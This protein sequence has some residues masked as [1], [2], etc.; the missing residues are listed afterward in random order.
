MMLANGRISWTCCR[1]D[2]NARNGN[3]LSLLLVVIAVGLFSAAAEPASV[4]ILGRQYVRVSDWA[5]KSGL[6]MRWLKQDE[7]LQLGNSRFKIRLTINSSDADVNGVDVRLLFPVAARNGVPYLAQL[8]ADDTLRPILFPPKNRPGTTVKTICLDPGHGGNDPGYKIAGR[9]E[10]N[11]TLLLG[12]ELR[13]QLV[14]AGFKVSLTRTS[15]KKIELP[16]R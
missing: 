2:V 13:D 8:D 11:L 6:E 1:K 7:T 16:M 15:D 12:Q 14:K 10:K 5:Q 4:A 3:G 9:E